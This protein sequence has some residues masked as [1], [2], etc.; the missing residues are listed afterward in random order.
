MDAPSGAA[1]MVAISMTRTPWSGGLA[2]R[3]VALDDRGDC[4]HALNLSST[5]VMGA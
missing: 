3:S 1:M 4:R 2:A 5:A